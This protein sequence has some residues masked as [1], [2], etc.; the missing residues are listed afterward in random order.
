MRFFK[1]TFIVLGALLLFVAC[2][3]TIP[4]G[5]K[6]LYRGKFSG[7]KEKVYKDGF[8]WHWLWNNVI[9]Y[10]VRWKTAIEELNILSADNLHMDVEVA[11]RLKPVENELYQLHTEIGPEYYLQVVRQPFR[12][13][14]LT[15]LADYNFNDIPKRTIEIQNKILDA[16][17]GELEGKHLDFDAV[18]LRHVEYPATVIEA[19]NA[20]LATQQRM[21]QKEFEKRIAEADAQIKVIDARGQQQAQQIVDSTLTPLYLQ[22]RAIETQRAL[23]NSQNATFYFVPM[24]KDGLPVIIEAPMTEKKRATNAR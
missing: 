8:K 2:G 5:H 18:E 10:D 9:T 21:E 14:A 19:T 3:S 13:I 20:K 1:I 22:F 23:A 6:G 4:S 24:G 7:T 15:A 17:R 11:L 16:L 12:A